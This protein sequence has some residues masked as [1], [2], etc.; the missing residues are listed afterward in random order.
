M[1]KIE[2]ELLRPKC[3]T[4][5]HMTNALRQHLQDCHHGMILSMY[6]HAL[7]PWWELCCGVGAMMR[8]EERDQETQTKEEFLF[9][10]MRPLVKVRLM[11]EVIFLEPED[12]LEMR[13]L[14]AKD[15]TLREI[16]QVEEEENPHES[17]TETRDATQC[18]VLLGEPEDVFICRDDS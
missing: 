16:D 18:E 8:P 7:T 15:A 17:Y 10:V 11:V 1:P 9:Q 3:P 14:N 5:F 13:K 2:E 6:P 12:E 4:T